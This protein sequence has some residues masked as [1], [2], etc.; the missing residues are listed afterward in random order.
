LD[1][2]STALVRRSYGLNVRGQAGVEL[3][4]FADVWCYVHSD[5]GKSDVP[6]KASH[7]VV[8]RILPGL[9]VAILLGAA[10]TAHSSQSRDGIPLVDAH[11]HLNDPDSALALLQRKG[12]QAAVV[13]IGARGSNDEVLQAASRSGGRLIPFASVSPERAEYRERWQRGDTSLVGEL[14]A[15]FQSGQFRGIGEI[16]VVHFA[17]D[18]PAI[19]A[20]S[21]GA[22][23]ATRRLATRRGDSSASTQPTVARTSGGFPEA[24]FDPSGAIMRGIMRVAER[25]QLPVMIHCEVT[26][27]RELEALLKAFPSV[28]VIWA[29]GGYTPL[30]LA[31]RMLENH[32]NLVYD[33]SARTWSRHP[34]SP[35]YTIF[36][37]D[38]LVWPEWIALIERHSNRVIV[39]SDASQRSMEDDGRKIDRVRLLLG[40]LSDTTRKRVA[41]ENVLRLVT[42]GR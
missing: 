12:V 8:M 1:H 39:G 38:S 41:V 17:S 29:H 25:R 37:N 22:A 35:D 21:A 14:D 28:R 36:R 26:R 27:L 10:V 30:V 19:G 23:R 15:R 9:Y 5:G 2:G 40:Q 31:A 11:V 13:F 3:T 18:G 4:P 32:P 20:S 7:R 34:R 33:L 42:P 6:H 16:S 24:D